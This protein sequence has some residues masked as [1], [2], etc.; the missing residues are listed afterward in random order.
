MRKNM[1]FYILL[2]CS[3]PYVANAQGNVKNDNVLYIVDGTP[4]NKASINTNEVLIRQTLPGNRVNFERDF[5]SIIVIV[6]K[7]SAIVQYQKKLS[8]FSKK[9]KDYLSANQNSDADCGYVLDASFLW[10]KDSVNMIKRLYDVPDKKIK[11]VVFEENSF[12]N[13]G[14]SKKYNMFITTKK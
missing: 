5:D 14:V 3:L 11:K 10:I 12:Y 13:G 9:Y 4:V 6:T 1:I 2:C 7:K 8:A